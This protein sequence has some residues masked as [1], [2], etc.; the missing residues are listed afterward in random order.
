MADES[1]GDRRKKYKNTLVGA[2]G[3]PTDP[4]AK[5]PL[6]SD[7]AS[8]LT[9][10]KKSDGGFRA[11]TAGH[12]E[13]VL[14]GKSTHPPPDARNAQ[15]VRPASKSD[16]PAFGPDSNPRPADPG[17]DVE[18]EVPKATSIPSDLEESLR[19]SDSPDEITTEPPPSSPL[20][21]KER[22]NEAPQIISTG[23]DDGAYD[24]EII[25]QA[26][27]SRSS[28]VPILIGVLA[29]A[30]VGGVVVWV[31]MFSSGDPA[32]AS[33]DEPAVPTAPAPPPVAGVDP[34]VPP[35]PEPSDSN[36]PD[37]GS[38]VP[39]DDLTEPTPE[40]NGPGPDITPASGFEEP[41]VPENLR[42][43]GVWQRRQRARDLIRDARSA[44]ARRA[45]QRAEMLWRDSL[46]HEPESADASA[47]L[48]RTLARLARIEEALEWAKRAV[49]LDDHPRFRELAGDLLLD[50][51][52][53]DEALAQYRAGLEV[54]PDDARLRSR[55]HRLG[56]RL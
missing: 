35:P 40:S 31:T 28:L 55:I 4:A 16:R 5:S 54:A 27:S 2:G 23:P 3:P 24:S 32:T 34:P 29:F 33:S 39:P 19:H 50:L 10:G 37:D 7:D 51:R 14:R 52:R 18:I 44:H 21:R 49:R 48:A 53:E 20:A 25:T 17:V 11:P 43:L 26:A 6:T 8:R 42:R 9:R 36:A 46:S 12:S 15:V 45:Y 38:P 56:H 1:Q 47:G 22:R 13:V 30:V 41:V